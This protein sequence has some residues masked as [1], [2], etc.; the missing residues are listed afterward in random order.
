[1][2]YK[3]TEKVLGLVE[4]L[5]NEGYDGEA[6]FTNCYCTGTGAV[7]GE[8]Y[9][10]KLTGFC[11]EYLHLTENKESGKVLFVGRYSLENEIL[12]PTVED[13]VYCAWI[14]YKTYKDRGYSMPSEFRDLFEKYG[15]I[16]KKIITQ[17]I[18][19]EK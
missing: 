7:L 19:E 15:Y 9:S 4:E 11:K 14:M 8:S 6:T 16:E 12:N 3:V 18:W 17:E 13:I 2:T 5:F 10:I 1:M